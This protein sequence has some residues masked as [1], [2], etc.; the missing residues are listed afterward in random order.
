MA[1]IRNKKHYGTIEYLERLADELEFL[2]REHYLDRKNLVLIAYALP[3]KSKKSAKPKV[4][5]DKRKE[6]FERR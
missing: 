1:K 5:R 3:R 6:K 2:G 4:D